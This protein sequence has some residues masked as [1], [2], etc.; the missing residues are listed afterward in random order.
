MIDGLPKSS[1]SR[2]FRRICQQLITDP[3]LSSVVKTWD[4]WDGAA[5]HASDV[6]TLDPL[7]RLTPQLGPVDW[8]SPDAQFGD[9]EIKV[10]IGVD[11]FDA[12][13]CLDLW[14]A[15][16]RA[17]YPYD[18][19]AKQLAFE[20]ALVGLGC[21]TGQITFSN[22]ASIQSAQDGQFLCLGMMRVKIVRA[23]NP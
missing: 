15:F 12:G 5:D 19:A 9:L 2:V 3:V 1:R 20:A 11:S 23:F 4:T 6:V 7:V 21:E 17:I 16:E 13:D 10:E 14:D 22:P 8:Y 18:D